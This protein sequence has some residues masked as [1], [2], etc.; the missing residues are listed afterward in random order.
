MR[1]S[2]RLI[3]GFVLVWGSLLGQD[4]FPA[5]IEGE[6]YYCPRIDL[7]AEDQGGPLGI[8]LDGQLGDQAW[9]RVSW[10]TWSIELESARG[11][12][13]LD[14]D[15]DF[16][17]EWAA[18]A[19]E[20]YL[21]FACRVRDDEVCEGEEAL[22]CDVWKDDSV[23]I[24]IDALNDGPD[25]TVDASA[26]CYGPDD[27]QITIGAENK[28]RTDPDDLL[29]GG[30]GPNQVCDY[31]GPHSE[32]A[33]GVATDYY[34]RGV[35]LGWQAEVAIAL[36]TIGNDDDGTPAWTIVPDHG[37]VIGFNVHGNDDD[38]FGDRD[39][40][41]IWSLLE[42]VES[43]FRNPGVFGKL[44]FIDP[45]RGYLPVGGLACTRDESGS[46]IVTW[47]NPVCADAD[48]PTRIL[49][50]GAEVTAVGGSETKAVLTDQQVPRD[51]KDHRITVVNDSDLPASCDII[52]APFDACGAIRSWNV[53]GAFI[54]P[55]RAIPSLED[56]RKDYMTDG[57]T[58]DLD[59]D[60][61]PGASIATDFGGAAWSASVDGGPAGRNPGGLPT[62]F[63]RDEEEGL[64]DL[65]GESGFG[66]NI[67]YGMVYLQAYVVAEKEASLFL[68]VASSD[69]VQ[70]LVDGAEGFIRRGTRSGL[71][72]CAPPD[73]SASPVTLRRGI[74]RLLVKSFEGSGS[75]WHLALRFQDAQ[76]SPVTEGLDIRLKPEAT[77]I[78]F[79]RGDGNGDG[80][81]DIGDAIRV[82]N[83]LF[84]SGPMECVDA[85]D[86]NDDGQ[87][88]IGDGIRLLNFLFASG[89]APA[90][91]GTSC[92]ADPTGDSLDCASYPS[93]S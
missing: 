8:A 41:L 86:V 2:I 59:F 93:C 10:H 26:A 71:D 76:G 58:S 27:A 22:Q 9:R 4:P 62:V 12:E 60:W 72:P 37:T 88:D 17:L 29:I 19:D 15:A 54:Y 92:G 36:W 55:S 46:M 57:R 80:V 33:R 32:V 78:E 24:Y 69:S 53:I 31:D 65:E 63:V 87:L 61:R 20:E 73:V 70:V 64:F 13:G 38:G 30:V 3:I 56:M 1:E 43:S 25:C 7:V 74:N 66:G 91:P 48:I 35:L 11:G 44:M 45:K 50:D 49:V 47:T 79:R 39:H 16:R 67:D 82:L 23:E 77:A 14:P 81:Y 75:T 90:P 42:T 52:Q 34:E 83:H 6:L 21:Y 51:R 5:G 18:V 84:A 89:P 40:K 85:A 68:G 28:N